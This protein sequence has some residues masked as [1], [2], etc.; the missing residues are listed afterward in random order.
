MKTTRTMQ[1][2]QQGKQ[3]K[4]NI[5]TDWSTTVCDLA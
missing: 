5:Y 4:V 1:N 3:N 2:I